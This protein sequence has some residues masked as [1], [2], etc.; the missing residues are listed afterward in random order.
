MIG[1]LAHRLQSKVSVLASIPLPGVKTDPIIVDRQRQRMVFGGERNLG[2]IHS[3]VFA[4]ITQGLLHN[5]HQ[6]QFGFG[7]QF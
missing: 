6:V 1:A 3:G 7:I 5:S 2:S 4:H